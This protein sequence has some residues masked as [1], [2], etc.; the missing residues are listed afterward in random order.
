MPL[1][2]QLFIVFSLQV[3]SVYV[4]IYMIYNTFIERYNLNI[5]C[6]SNFLPQQ[7]FGIWALSFPSQEPMGSIC[8]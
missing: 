7:Y 3:F 5:I 1:D 6:T 4:Y 8:L 2:I